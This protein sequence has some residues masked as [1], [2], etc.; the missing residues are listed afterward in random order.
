MRRVAPTGVAVGMLAMLLALV[1]GGL[2]PNVAAV[3]PD[4]SDVVMEFDFSSSITTNKTTRTQLASAIDQIANRVTETAD[5]LVAGDTT[6]SLIQFATRAIDVHD[7]VDLGLLNNP[8]NVSRF[9][10][11]LHQVANQYK[12][13]GTP[14]LKAAI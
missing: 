9:A 5:T 2:A 10:S 1:A 6:V 11:C 7:C 4:K 13:G 8:S 3:G 14:A 12:S